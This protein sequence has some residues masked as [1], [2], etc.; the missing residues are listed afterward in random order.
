M[1][2]LWF[3][4]SIG[5]VVVL[6]FIVNSYLKNKCEKN[7]KNMFLLVVLL[8][9]F[10]GLIFS[11]M[12]GLVY[13]KK[14]ALGKPAKK[15]SSENAYEVFSVKESNGAIFSALIIVKEMKPGAYSFEYKVWKPLVYSIRDSDWNQLGLDSIPKYFTYR[16][17]GPSSEEIYSL[18]SLSEIS[19]EDWEDWK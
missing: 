17:R 1:G 6:G 11:H 18:F 19:K 16:E 5:T 7:D 14:Q 13:G 9:V 12:S 15:L 8:I 2:I 3:F 10:A 4:A